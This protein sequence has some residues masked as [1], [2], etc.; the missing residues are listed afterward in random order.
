MAET[1]VL[2]SGIYQ[3]EP[4]AAPTAKVNVH[5]L[6]GELLVDVVDVVSFDVVSEMKFAF[7]TSP[8]LCV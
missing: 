2:H 7:F 3:C 8:H 6:D 1:D 5:V 4:G